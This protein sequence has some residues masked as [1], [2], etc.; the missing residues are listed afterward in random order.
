MRMRVEKAGPADAD[1]L[2]EMRLAYLT[3][4]FGGLE[5]EEASEIRKG[6]PSYFRRHLGRDLSVFV[7]REGEA[8]VTCA[9]LLMLEKPMSPAFRNGKTGMVLNVYTRP[10]FRR[11][12]CARAVMAALME[13]AR[14]RELSAVELKATEEGV[15]LYRFAGFTEDGSKYLRMIWKP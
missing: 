8:I 11:R 10:A 5:E 6:L 12:G 9:F 4:D 2:T 7:A 3:E 1:A 15:P 14:E 13:E